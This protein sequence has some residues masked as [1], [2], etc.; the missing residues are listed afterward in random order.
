MKQ[1]LTLALV[2]FTGFSLSAQNPTWAEDIAPILYANC[3]KCHNPNGIAP[4][5]LL[6]YTD[7]A[8]NGAA[9]S[10]SVQNREMP[11]WPP[12][13]S[14]TR[15][16]S[17]RMLSQQDIQAIADW[18][19][20]GM[21]SGNLSQAPQQPVYTSVAEIV[22]PDLS[23]QIPDYTVNTAG[24]LYRCFAIPSGIST[25]E[26]LTKI[27]V[28]PGNR[29]IVHHVLIY[30]DQANTCVNLDNNDPNPGY[31][32]FGGVGS[33]T[34]TLIMG[35]VPGQGMYE[36]PPNMGIRLQPNAN[37]ILQIHYPGGTVSQLDS[38][39]VRFTFSSVNVR[40]VYVNPV[41]N[42][43][44]SLTNGPL[45]IPADSVKLFHAQETATYNVSVISVAPHMHLIGRNVVNFAI[46]P[47]GDT[48]P[49]IRINNWNFHWQGFYNFRQPV[50]V[51]Y[52]SII[53]AAALY[54]NTTNNPWNPNN[55]AEAVHAGESTTDEMM[56][57]YY[58]YLLYQWN[59]EN[60]IID[61][62]ILAGTEDQSSFAIVKTPQL[63][64]PY[65][66]PAA[67]NSTLNISWFLPGQSTV[68]IE[69]LDISGKV[70]SVPVSDQRTGSGF[71]SAQI[72]T[73]GLAAGNYVVRFTAGET[74]LTKSVVVSGF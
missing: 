48:I 16:C 47:S 74:V 66:V 4:F 28:L 62:T 5:S 71:G 45:Y 56:L 8:N 26:F 14:Y 41:I 55:P 38:T 43:A 3:T 25:T 23:L 11:P 37:I 39:Q 35:W 20:N 59:D 6:S 70:V 13:T 27:E 69:L 58:A 31:T 65:P 18:Y 15:F 40:E 52:G 72:A 10:N 33:A 64:A 63:Y 46:D 2:I 32:A 24:D 51:P 53:H 61:S 73:A 36:L 12:D 1:L 42:H 44:T 9:M 30:Q 57:I 19:S 54:D 22:S 29:S 7:A 68:R 50:H 34:A 17:E 21:P 60:I 49:L 67:E